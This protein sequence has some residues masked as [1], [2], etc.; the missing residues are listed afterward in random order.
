MRE[1]VI[2]LASLL[3]AAGCRS[4][5]AQYQAPPGF[6]IEPAAS[7]LRLSG[8]AGFTFD[9]RGRPVVFKERGFATLLLDN[10]GD[11]VFETEKIL[12]TQVGGVRGLWFDGRVLYVLAN[13]LFR[14]EDR[15]NDDEMESV[16]LL[17]SAEGA[18]DMRRSPDGSPTLLQGGK[19]Q[20]WNE[21]R[22]SLT[23]LASGFTNPRAHAYGPAGEA[24]VLDAGIFH[25]IPGGDYSAPNYHFDV[26]PPMR[27]A[28]ASAMEF[29]QHRV[30]PEAY[31]DA[32]FLAEHGRIAARRVLRSGATYRL[33]ESAIG[34]FSTNEPL[35]VTDIKVGPDGFV[36][37]TAGGLYRIRYTPSPRERWDRWRKPPVAPPQPLSSWGHAALSR[38]RELLASVWGEDLEARAL[39]AGTSAADR[40][41]AI[42]LLR[43]FGPRPRATL[44]KK[45][46]ADREPRVRA[47]AMFGSPAGLADPDPLVRRR[48]AEAVEAEF[49]PGIYG[50]LGD[51]DRF[52][53]YAARLALERTPR[54]EWRQRALDEGSLDGMLALVRAGGREDRESVLQKLLPALA[55][56]RVDTLRLFTLASVGVKDAAL[57]KQAVEILLPQF[58]VSGDEP[59]QREL[60]SALAWGGG[61][62]VIG[63]ILDA[64]PAAEKNRPLQLHL[65]NCLRLIGDGWTTGQRKTLAEFGLARNTLTAQEIYDLQ[66]ASPP[67]K[68]TLA[69]GRAIFEAR[70]ASCH[71]FGK[72]GIQAGPDLTNVVG[73]LEKPELLEAILWPSRAVPERYRTQVLTLADGSTLE[74]ILMR[75]DDKVLLLKIAGEP[76]PI[77]ILKN[78]VTS[79]QQT[80]QSVMPVGLLDSYGQSGV[81]SLLVFLATGPR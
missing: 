33:E 62:E 1:L 48:A 55:E 47:A 65:A 60:A 6:S 12:N 74:G 5:P 23:V 30:Y 79:R 40:V 11:G 77:S 67:P 72:L 61:T 13:G 21:D 28:P 41:Q 24:F 35:H 14:L 75:E 70:C 34:E 9:S 39:E 20:R 71:G 7:P 78:R 32:L 43:R 68:G 69:K 50:L 58:D 36:Y 3:A 27:E 4:R 15:N 56:P 19:L 29:Y 59:L 73:R 10:N 38:E 81:A 53:R 44:L 66:M 80:D 18:R 25:A 45:L 57:Q 49:A 37:F 64:I 54:E 76:N 42:L 16:E 17:S 26:L 46:Q 63:K 51:S 2:V 22:R 31:R 52:V 8:L